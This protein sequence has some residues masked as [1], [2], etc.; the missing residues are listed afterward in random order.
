MRLLLDRMR[1]LEKRVD[2]NADQDKARSNYLRE[3]LARAEEERE[4]MRATMS[5]LSKQISANSTMIA[6]RSSKERDVTMYDYGARVYAC[7]TGNAMVSNSSSAGAPPP[8]SM[9]LRDDVRYHPT[10][11]KS[12]P[13]PPVCSGNSTGNTMI[14]QQ[15][16]L[17]QRERGKADRSSDVRGQG[18]GMVGTAPN[19]P[20]SVN[21]VASAGNIPAAQP[22]SSR[23]PDT[24][25]N[26]PHKN[27]AVDEPWAEDH[28]SDADLICMSDQAETY[29]N[30]RQNGGA[31]TTT[32]TSNNAAYDGATRG[33]SANQPRY[34]PQSAPGNGNSRKGEKRVN[35][36]HLDRPS[37]ERESY[38]GAASKYNW[39]TVENKRSKRNSDDGMFMLLGVKSTPHKEIFV[40]HLDYTR[41]SKPA[42]LEGRV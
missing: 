26:P 29:E 30:R 36:G 22:S 34:G 14:P 41:C 16:P 11:K 19:P 5:V 21:G 37:D 25:S 23:Q 20:R 33:S 27:Y 8:S 18:Q 31:S 28:M 13:P 3:R 12:N 4:K 42:D 40:K 38:A 17:P 10:S 7:Q 32:S 24:V 9:Q 35:N 2:S 6:E 15:V 39:N 1:E